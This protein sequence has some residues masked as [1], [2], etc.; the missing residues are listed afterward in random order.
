MTQATQIIASIQADSEGIP[1]YRIVMTNPFNGSIGYSTG[2]N[3][4]S[5]FP[6]AYIGVTGELG[7][8]PDAVGDC[9]VA[10]IAYVQS[11]EGQLLPGSPIACDQVGRAVPVIGPGE[12]IVGFC[13]ENQ[14]TTL[15][16]IVKVI[17][18]PG[19]SYS[20]LSS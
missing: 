19:S 18:S 12:R 17:V 1:P 5:G 8:D 13:L 6:V 11:G 10:G 15:G 7:I 2:N 14:P 4:V 3:L 20:G 16:Q 9:T